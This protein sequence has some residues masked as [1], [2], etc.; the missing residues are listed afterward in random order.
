MN[1]YL[2]LVI[3]GGMPR[4]VVVQAYDIPGAVSCCGFLQSDVIRVELIGSMDRNDLTQGA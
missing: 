3:W 1:K 2:L 4:E